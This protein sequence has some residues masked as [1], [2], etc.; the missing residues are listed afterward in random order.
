MATKRERRMR[1][2]QVDAEE[3]AAERGV[4]YMLRGDR[5]PSEH[6]RWMMEHNSPVYSSSL[7]GT[8]FAFRVDEGVREHGHPHSYPSHHMGSCGES[9]RRGYQQHI[10]GRRVRGYI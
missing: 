6:E 3:R 5:T 2:E 9:C 10:H 1:R 4:P 7:R 8:R